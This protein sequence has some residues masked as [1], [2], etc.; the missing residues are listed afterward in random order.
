VL[1]SIEQTKIAST[2]KDSFAEPDERHV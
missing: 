1:H 2:S